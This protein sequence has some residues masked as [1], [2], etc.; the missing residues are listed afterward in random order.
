M[1]IAEMVTQARRQAEADR[2]TAIRA[3]LRDNYMIRRRAV[4]NDDDC[5]GESALAAYL[6][7]RHR[8][9]ARYF[10]GER[11]A[12]TEEAGKVLAYRRAA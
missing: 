7:E 1:D 2:A 6:D 8:G 12:E 4:W 5:H 10:D 11:E 9:V 3:Q